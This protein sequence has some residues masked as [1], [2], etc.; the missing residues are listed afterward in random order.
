VDSD[1]PAI[2][3]LLGAEDSLIPGL[4]AD[5]VVNVISAVGNYAE[6]YDRNLGPGTPM[7]LERGLNALYTDGGILY[8]APY[9]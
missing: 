7:A 5:W 4:D 3:R 1:N 2:A 8:A 9:R 6:I